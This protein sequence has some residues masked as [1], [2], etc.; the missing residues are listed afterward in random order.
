VARYTA[1]VKTNFSIAPRS[2]SIS[3]IV[4]RN[5]G[6]SEQHEDYQQ[7]DWHPIS[8]DGAQESAQLHGSVKRSRHQHTREQQ[9]LYWQEDLAM[10]VYRHT[11]ALANWLQHRTELQHRMQDDF[12]DRVNAADKEYWRCNTAE[13]IQVVLSPTAI[14]CTSCNTRIAVLPVSRD[15]F[16][17]TSCQATVWYDQ[18]LLVATEAAQHSGPVHI[19]AH[20]A[21]LRRLHFQ[22]ASGPPGI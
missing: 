11:C 5:Q 19:Q 7:A 20:S 14:T 1:Q 4:V 9:Y 16:P 2:N 17:S 22:K 21:G 15:C 10:N 8:P 13:H 6:A 3:P 12:R 18:Q